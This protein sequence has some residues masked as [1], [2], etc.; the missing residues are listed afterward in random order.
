MATRATAAATKASDSEIGL[1]FL[2]GAQCDAG[3]YLV[4]DRVWLLSDGSFAACDGALVCNLR[5]RAFAA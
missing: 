3:A 4:A 2:E 1:Q 5:L